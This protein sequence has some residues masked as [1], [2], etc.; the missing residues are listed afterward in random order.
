M[1]GDCPFLGT[2]T[3]HT[4]ITKLTSKNNLLRNIFLSVYLEEHIS[5]IKWNRQTNKQKP[6]FTKWCQRALKLREEEGIVKQGPFSAIMPKFLH[7]FKKIFYLG[8]HQLFFKQFEE[9]HA[10]FFFFFHEIYQLNNNF[11]NNTYYLFPIWR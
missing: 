1:L 4:G 9:Y 11:G 6:T 5:K 10:F 2:V 3:N 8:L 7:W